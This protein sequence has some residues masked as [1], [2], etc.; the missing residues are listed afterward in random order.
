MAAVRQVSMLVPKLRLSP[1]YIEELLS[2]PPGARG[3]A[4][5]CTVCR[6]RSGPPSFQQGRGQECR[7]GEAGSSQPVV[8]GNSLF[9]PPRPPTIC[10]RSGRFRR[11]PQ[12]EPWK[13]SLRC[14]GRWNA[15]LAPESS[16][17]AAA[18]WH[19]PAGGVRRSGRFL[20]GPWKTPEPQRVQCCTQLGFSDSPG[21]LRTV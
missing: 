9:A 18:A 21:V 1:P 12:E 19:A 15:L 5:R 4:Y 10:T 17:P 11:D 20:P 2:V 16:R 6:L 8:G 7:G 14:S 3:T 13:E